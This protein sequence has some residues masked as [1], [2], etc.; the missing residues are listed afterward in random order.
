GLGQPGT[1]DPQRSQQCR[2]CVTYCKHRG[3][4]SS[5]SFCGPIYGERKMLGLGR[6]PPGIILARLAPLNLVRTRSTASLT[7]PGMNGRR[8][9]ASLPSL[10]T[11]SGAGG[12]R[13]L[14]GLPQSKRTA[15]E[16]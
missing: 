13:Q 14:L 2:I 9:N 15:Q 5:N 11:G 16:L 12:P 4:G 10:K 6:E 3:T 8:W 7:S 1:R